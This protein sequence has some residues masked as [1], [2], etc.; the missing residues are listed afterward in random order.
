MLAISTRSAAVLAA[1]SSVHASSE[2]ARP[3]DLGRYAPES[4]VTVEQ[5]LEWLQDKLNDLHHAPVVPR[6][7]IP[8]LR[9]ISP[10]EQQALKLTD[11]KAKVPAV[12]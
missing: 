6:G 7:L 3:F 4:W 2:A 8:G 11:W 12:G 10:L 5:D 9:D 1:S